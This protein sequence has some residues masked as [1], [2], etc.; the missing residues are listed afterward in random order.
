M[1]EF[2]TQ[3]DEHR[4]L[5]ETAARLFR[6][7]AHLQRN[8]AESGLLALPFAEADGGWRADGSIDRTDQ[9]IAFAAKGQ[10]YCAESTFLQVVLGGDLIAASSAGGQGRHRSEH[11]RRP[12]TNRGWPP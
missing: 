3:T 8:L 1:V 6:E 7:P 12:R 4:L 2:L 5:H 11:H 10:A 9:A